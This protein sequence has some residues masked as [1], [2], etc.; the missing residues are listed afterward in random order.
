VQKRSAAEEIAVFDVPVY[1][2]RPF[3]RYGMGEHSSRIFILRK[4]NSILRH[5]QP[6]SFYE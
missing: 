5:I 6:E 2:D 3:F 1:V 4:I